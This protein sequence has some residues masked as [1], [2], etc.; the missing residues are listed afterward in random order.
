MIVEHRCYQLH[1]GKLPAYLALFQLPGVLPRLLRHMRG[2][3]IAESGT[4]NRVHHIW[5]YADRA[6][7]AAARQQMAADPGMGPFLAG[8]LPLLQAQESRVLTGT[9]TAPDAAG[10]GGVFDLL[11]LELDASLESKGLLAGLSGKIGE[12]AAIVAALRESALEG[13]TL[14]GSAL[15][16]LRH[17][18]FAARD[19]AVPA[20]ETLLADARRDGWLRNAGACFILPAPFSPWQ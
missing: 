1:M 10:S 20:I 16:I 14:V 2:Y 12:K 4:V 9:I 18:S 6:E 5:S 13:D 11:S 3:W 15:F 8:A 17:A 7:R 19:Q